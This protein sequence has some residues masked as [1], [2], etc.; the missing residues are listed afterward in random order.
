MAYQRSISVKTEEEALQ[1]FIDGGVKFHEL[2]ADERAE[3]VKRTRPVW[4]QF[5]DQIPEELL[6][7]VRE[8]QK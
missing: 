5:K 2:T 6:K 7:I 8:T 1:K 4:D 3:F